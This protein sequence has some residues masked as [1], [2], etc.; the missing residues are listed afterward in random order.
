MRIISS[1]FLLS[2][3]DAFVYRFSSDGRSNGRGVKGNRQSPFLRTNCTHFFPA[4]SS[5]CLK[6]GFRN[7]RPRQP[8]SMDSTGK[9]GKRENGYRVLR[10][11]S[12]Y[13]AVM[14]NVPR[15]SCLVS[16]GVWILEPDLRGV[17]LGEKQFVQYREAFK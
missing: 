3:V 1:L 14:G 6:G 15:R 8:V 2:L 5:L 17:V 12:D 4:K 10:S 11:Y 9:H 7:D 16:P 13:H